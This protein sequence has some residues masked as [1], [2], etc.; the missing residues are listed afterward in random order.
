MLPGM[1]YG[2][3]RSCPQIRFVILRNGEIVA[4]DLASGHSLWEY[5]LI[6]AVGPLTRGVPRRYDQNGV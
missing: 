3:G 2:S 5:W 1:I 4:E 6:A